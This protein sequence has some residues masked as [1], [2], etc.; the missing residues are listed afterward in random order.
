MKATIL[1]A[2]G[3]LANRLP[4]GLAPLLPRP[5]LSAAYRQL[6]RRHLEGI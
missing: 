2:A 5:V 3:W 4:A 6:H 1:W